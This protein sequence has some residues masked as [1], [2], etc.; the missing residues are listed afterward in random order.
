MSGEAKFCPNCGKPVVAGPQYT[1][2]LPVAK[3]RKWLIPTILIAVVVAGTITGVLGVTY[4]I[5]LGSAYSVDHWFCSTG[6]IDTTSGSLQYLYGVR[7]TGGA[8]VHAEWTVVTDYGRGVVVRGTTAF[9]V[10]SHGTA[11][12]TFNWILTPAQVQQVNSTTM[13]TSTFTRSYSV[14]IYTFHLQSS[15]TATSSRPSPSVVNC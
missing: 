13:I 3:A 15:D 8:D 10:A 2:P 9:T 6:T 5:A 11:Y 12:P 7:N 4:G 1:M 14:Y